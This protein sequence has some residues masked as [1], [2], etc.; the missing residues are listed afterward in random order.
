MFNYNDGKID[1]LCNKCGKS[2][3]RIISTC[4]QYNYCGLME[5]TVKGCYGSDPLEDL[6][7]YTF[8]LCE[9]CL[10]ELF[11]SF[12]LPVKEEDYSLTSDYKL[13]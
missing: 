1:I 4:G 5:I 13:I 10:D 6:K 11:K 8:S 9:N 7:S 2:L 12:K 3:K